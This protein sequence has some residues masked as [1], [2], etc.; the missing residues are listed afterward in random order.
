L[1]MSE[2]RQISTDFNTFGTKNAQD[3]ELV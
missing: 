2:L 3:D 1:F